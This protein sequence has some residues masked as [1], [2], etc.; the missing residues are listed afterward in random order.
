MKCILLKIKASETSVRLRSRP[1]YKDWSSCAVLQLYE[2]RLCYVDLVLLPFSIVYSHL[3][4]LSVLL[5]IVC[6]WIQLCVLC[7]FPCIPISSY[8]QSSAFNNL[9]LCILT[10]SVSYLGCFYQNVFFNLPLC[11]PLLFFLPST[12]LVF[13]YFH[14]LLILVLADVLQFKVRNFSFEIKG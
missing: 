8:I 4:L 11:L 1:V 9:S 6:I 12:Y 13:F 10:F 7:D 3:H 5:S 2:L 14:P